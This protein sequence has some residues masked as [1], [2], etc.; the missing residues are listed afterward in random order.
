MPKAR[1]PEQREWLR[2]PLPRNRD[3]ERSPIMV[4]GVRR[5]HEV[6]SGSPI[7]SILEPATLSALNTL[8]DRLAREGR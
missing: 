7:H 1:R 5:V 6:R 3:T 8:R 4:S 2:D